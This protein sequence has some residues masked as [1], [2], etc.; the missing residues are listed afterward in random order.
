MTAPSGLAYRAACL[1]PGIYTFHASPRILTTLQFDTTMPGEVTRC[2]NLSQRRPIAP[3]GCAVR[4][5]CLP[6]VQNYRW[7]SPPMLAPAQDKTAK[8][9]LPSRRTSLDGNISRDLT[10]GNGAICLAAQS[11]R[12]KIIFSGRS[13]TTRQCT[14]FTRT[15]C[16]HKTSSCRT[17]GNM[18]KCERRLLRP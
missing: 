13:T 11:K 18:F 12:L 5:S 9:R 4:A 14:N 6:S 8:V 1:L 2:C 17:I 15:R 7:P 3:F 16:H 10:V